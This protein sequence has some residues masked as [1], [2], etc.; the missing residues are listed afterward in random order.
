M[1][2]NGTPLNNCPLK[3]HHLYEWD[4]AGNISS[5]HI[6]YFTDSDFIIVLDTLKRLGVP[7]HELH[8]LCVLRDMTIKEGGEGVSLYVNPSAFQ[9]RK[10]DTHIMNYAHL[11]QPDNFQEATDE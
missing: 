2:W 7:N 10:S 8:G 3:S 1:R 4:G 11:L 9:E 6:H 5:P